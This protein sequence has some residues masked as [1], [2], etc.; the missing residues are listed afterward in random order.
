MGG[1][2]VKAVADVGCSVS[3]RL[4]QVCHGGCVNK[5]GDD[6]WLVYCVTQAGHADGFGDDIE[7]EGELAGGIGGGEREHGSGAW[8]PPERRSA[9]RLGNGDGTGLICRDR[10]TP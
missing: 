6:L 3:D 7:L 2:L 9:V 8:W 10:K 5:C 1:H 4:S